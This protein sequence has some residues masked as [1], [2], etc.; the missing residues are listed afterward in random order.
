MVE[1]E[2]QIALGGA[3]RTLDA[4]AAGV[5]VAQSVKG[6]LNDRRER[7][8]AAAAV[9]V[10]VVVELQGIVELDVIRGDR[11]DGGG[12]DELALRLLNKRRIKHK[13]QVQVDQTSVASLTLMPNSPSTSH[14]VY[15]GERRIMIYLLGR[16]SKELLDPFSFFWRPW[17][18][19]WKIG[20]IDRFPQIMPRRK[21]PGC[22]KLRS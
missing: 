19:K 4:D 15:Q 21:R 8:T 7:R 22:N 11:R 5:H 20:R 14:Q 16:G 3:S 17:S 6:G 9:V 13:P 12:R 1:R 18:Q 2:R 10:V